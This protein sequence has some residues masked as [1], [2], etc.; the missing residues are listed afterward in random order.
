MAY[1]VKYRLEFSDDLENVKKIEIL[2]KNYTAAVNDLV[3]GA[4]PCVISWQ[5]DDNFYS[6]I[7]G[8]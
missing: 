6:P 2:K 3:G 4:D 5:G 1:G 8:S 7:K